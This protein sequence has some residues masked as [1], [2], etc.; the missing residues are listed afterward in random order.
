MEGWG[1]GA[2]VLINS[3]PDAWR[4]AGNSES[5]LPTGSSTQAG[6]LLWVTPALLQFLTSEATKHCWPTYCRSPVRANDRLPGSCHF[7]WVTPTGWHVLDLE[8]FLHKRWMLT[9]W[10]EHPEREEK[11]GQSETNRERE[12]RGERERESRPG[13]QRPLKGHPGSP[14][15]TNSPSHHIM[16]RIYSIVL[17][18]WQDVTPEAEVLEY[19]QQV[20]LQ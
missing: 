12:K 5:S 8:S 7:P 9:S 20:Y 2:A 3:S 14:E 17:K 11:V 6:E 16:H 19:L 18:D 10:Q 15:F 13:T 4:S 1:W